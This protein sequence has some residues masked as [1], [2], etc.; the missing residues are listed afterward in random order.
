LAKFSRDKRDK[1]LKSLEYHLRRAMVLARQAGEIGLPSLRN[2]GWEEFRDTSRPDSDNPVTLASE[3]F[4]CLSRDAYGYWSGHLR[5][6]NAIL[7]F[8]DHQVGRGPT[9]EQ[10]RALATLLRGHTVDA[11]AVRAWFA[12][13]FG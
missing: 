12:S 11:D 7:A 13:V 9:E 5:I 4:L 8:L 2:L 1:V 6:L 10:L 3:T